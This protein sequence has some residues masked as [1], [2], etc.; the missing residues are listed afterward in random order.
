MI[1]MKYTQIRPKLDALAIGCR[2]YLQKEQIS[3]DPMDNS[4]NTA[5]LC[6]AVSKFM[7]IEG[8]DAAE[9]KSLCLLYQLLIFITITEGQFYHFFNSFPNFYLFSRKRSLPISLAFTFVSIVRRLGLPAI[10]INSRFNV[11]ARVREAFVDVFGPPE[12]AIVDASDGY[13]ES[14]YSQ[15]RQRVTAREMLARTAR[16][17]WTAGDVTESGHDHLCITA[18][19]RH[20]A[21]YTLQYIRLAIGP[22]PLAAIDQEFLSQ[23]VHHPLDLSLVL[24]DKLDIKLASDGVGGYEN[25]DTVASCLEIMDRW[26][27]QYTKELLKGQDREEGQVVSFF[28]G[29]IVRDAQGSVGCIVGWTVRILYA[30]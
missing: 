25:G 3:Y 21:K 1:S 13:P 18:S 14:T 30:T 10:L 22:R 29:Q 4:F 16:N 17:I 23:A 8:Y 24:R 11:I 2:Q 26:E 28:V 6:I 27:N 12:L 5:K 9:G 7:R 20:R 19:Q 15:E